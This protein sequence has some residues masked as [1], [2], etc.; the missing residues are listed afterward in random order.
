M[1]E[2]CLSGGVSRGVSEVCEYVICVTCMS[3]EMCQY[4][5]VSM[6]L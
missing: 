4:K 3:M 1:Y 5:H 6:L 2:V